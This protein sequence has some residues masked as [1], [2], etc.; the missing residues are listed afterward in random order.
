MMESLDS[1]KKA[2][3]S[4]F[5]SFNVQDS[6]SSGGKAS[7]TP[8]KQINWDKL[9]VLLKPNACNGDI[10]NKTQKSE[11]E[12]VAI[13]IDDSASENSNSGHN[14]GSC[15]VGQSG[16]H[17]GDRS[18]AHSL[19]DHD[20][21]IGSFN[22]TSG[23]ISKARKLTQG[24]IDGFFQKSPPPVRSSEKTS[25]HSQSVSGESS[26]LSQNGQIKSSEQR[27]ESEKSRS[28]KSHHW[29]SSKS[30]HHKKERSHSHSSSK[31]HDSEKSSKSS[32]EKHSSSHKSSHHRHTKSTGSHSVSSRNNEIKKTEG[33][34]L[35]TFNMFEVT[36]MSLAK[37]LKQGDSDKVSPAKKSHTAVSA[38]EKLSK[39]KLSKTEDVRKDKVTEKDIKHSS[40]HEKSRHKSHEKS[41]NSTKE[42]AKVIEGNHRTP[43]KGR[44]SFK[45]KS[46][47]DSP[48][49]KTPSKIGSHSKDR[50]HSEEKR[51]QNST[52][53]HAKV[54]EGN[55]KTPEK[56][57]HSFKPSKSSQGSPNE[58]TPSKIGSHSKD[59]GHSEEK[60]TPQKHHT[61]QKPPT[62]QN[63][64]SSVKKD[65]KGDHRQSSSCRVITPEMIYSQVYGSDVSAPKV[66]NTLKPSS[67]TSL[68]KVEHKAS[69]K[70]HRE[71]SKDKSASHDIIP[72]KVLE[73]RAHDY[74][75]SKKVQPDSDYWTPKNVQSDKGESSQIL[76]KHFYKSD[77][78]EGLNAREGNSSKSH[79]KKTDLVDIFNMLMDPSDSESVPSK[80]VLKNV[81]QVPNKSPQVKT[82]NLKV[83]NKN[84]FATMANFSTGEAGDKAGLDDYTPVSCSPNNSKDSQDISESAAACSTPV[85]YELKK[86]SDITSVDSISALWTDSGTTNL[87]VPDCQAKSQDSIEEET[88]VLPSIPILAEIG[89]DSWNTGGSKMH[90]DKTIAGELDLETNVCRSKSDSLEEE[91]PESKTG[92][93]NLSPNPEEEVCNFVS[94]SVLRVPVQE[95][96]DISASVSPAPGEKLGDMVAP[97][98][99][100]HV[101]DLGG[102]SGSVPVLNSCSSDLTVDDQSTR[103]QTASAG[104]E[105]ATVE[106]DIVSL[107]GSSVFDDTASSCVRVDETSEMNYET[108]LTMISDPSDRDDKSSV[109]GFSVRTTTSTDMSSS[110]I[111]K[112]ISNDAVPDMSAVAT[113]SKTVIPMQKVTET[114]LTDDKDSI[115][116]DSPVDH[117]EN[118]E[119]KSADGA[120]NVGKVILVDDDTVPFGDEVC[121]VGK[122]C[123][124]VTSFSSLKNL[125]IDHEE[126]SLHLH[127]SSE[128]SL[129]SVS[130][131]IHC[132][133]T[134]E[135]ISFP[136]RVGAS[137]EVYADAFVENE[138]ENLE[139]DQLNCSNESVI[140]NCVI[141]GNEVKG[142]VE[143]VDLVCVQG[144]EGP[145]L[146]VE[147]QDKTSMKSTVVVEEDSV[148]SSNISAGDF[149][150]AGVIEAEEYD[151]ESV[152]DLMSEIDNVLME[153]GETG[154]ESRDQTPNRL[155]VPLE[156]LW[157][158]QP[159]K[160][161]E[162]PCD[163]QR[164]GNVPSVSSAPSKKTD[165]TISLIEKTL[166][167]SCKSPLQIPIASEAEAVSELKPSILRQE[168][169]LN[170]SDVD[171]KDAAEISKTSMSLESS[172][173]EEEEE[174]TPRQ[175]RSRTRTS[176][177]QSEFS[178]PAP[179]IPKLRRSF[180]AGDKCGL[181]AAVETV[182]KES[183]KDK[184][185]TKLQMVPKEAVGMKR[186]A[187][188][189]V[190]P[191]DIDFES[192][193][194]PGIIEKD[195]CKI[196]SHL[197]GDLTNSASD[198]GEL[199]RKSSRKRKVKSMGDDVI[200]FAEAGTMKSDF[201]TQAHEYFPK[202]VPDV[203]ASV[204]KETGSAK[205][206]K[207][208]LPAS[209]TNSVETAKEKGKKTDKASE[210]DSSHEPV[211]RLRSPA[212]AEMH[213]TVKEL[214]RGLPSSPG[215]F[216]K[217]QRKSLG[218]IK[219]VAGKESLSSNKRR[220]VDTKVARRASD[221]DKKRGRTV[222]CD[223]RKI[224]LSSSISKSNAIP[225]RKR[226]RS[227]ELSKKRS[228][229]SNVKRGRGRPKKDVVGLKVQNVKKSVEDAKKLKQSDSSD[230]SDNSDEEI[231]DDDDE[232]AAGSE[233]DSEEITD[234]ELEKT[235][236]SDSFAGPGRRKKAGKYSYKK[237]DDYRPANVGSGARKRGRPRKCVFR[238]GNDSERDSSEEFQSS[239]CRPLKRKM[240]ILS[241]VSKIAKTSRKTDALTAAEAA[242]AK[243]KAEKEQMKNRHRN[244]VKRAISTQNHHK[245]KMKPFKRK[246]VRAILVGERK[247][248][249]RGAKNRVSMYYS[250]GM[251]DM[252]SD[253]SEGE[254]SS[255][256]DDYLKDIYSLFGGD[257][258]DRASAD[259][260][261]QELDSTVVQN[262]LNIPYYPEI[263][264]AALRGVQNNNCLLVFNDDTHWNDVAEEM[265]SR[266]ASICDKFTGAVVT[267]IQYQFRD[268]ECSGYDSNEP[269]VK[270]TRK[271][272][273]NDTTSPSS[274]PRLKK[275]YVH[276]ETK[277]FDR[278]PVKLTRRE[279]ARTIEEKQD[280][281]QTNSKHVPSIASDLESTPIK[282][283]N[284]SESRNDTPG[285]DSSVVIIN[286]DNSQ[287]PRKKDL[288][289]DRKG[290]LGLYEEF[291]SMLHKEK[292]RDED[293]SEVVCLDGTECDKQDRNDTSEQDEGS[294]LAHN[295]TIHK[296]VQ[297]TSREVGKET[298][299]TAPLPN[300]KP[301]SEPMDCDSLVGAND[302]NENI[303]KSSTGVKVMKRIVKFSAS[304]EL[305]KSFGPDKEQTSGDVISNSCKSVRV[306]KLDVPAEETEEINKNSADSARGTL[307]SVRHRDSNNPSA[308]E[309]G[310]TVSDKETN[311]AIS[312]EKAT[313][314]DDGD[315]KEA[316]VSESITVTHVSEPNKL[317]TAANDEDTYILV[318]CDGEFVLDEKTNIMDLTGESD[319]AFLE[320]NASVLSMEESSSTADDPL[321]RE[322][323]EA[324]N[325]DHNYVKKRAINQVWIREEDYKAGL[326]N[327]AV[328]LQDIG[329]LLSFSNEVGAF[330]DNETR[331]TFNVQ[332]RIPPKQDE[333][334][335][336]CQ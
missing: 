214:R 67:K 69:E 23:T 302:E 319:V 123:E 144:E 59:R 309:Q 9:S 236:D 314:F 234:S 296:S 291:M 299:S 110:I 168:A 245:L 221:S 272:K 301:G 328:N 51:T 334:N 332:E 77:R 121:P 153:I 140:V 304:R 333:P 16:Y 313:D 275:K 187:N 142:C 336:D 37:R 208:N 44:H 303:S 32:G 177:S 127:L 86:V 28:E 292:K 276:N 39:D 132:S 211:R 222:S 178:S 293:E 322:L 47:Q 97:V 235:S 136:V 88:S 99:A 189:P 107:G 73:N 6:D 24:K 170:E 315:K 90:Q 45:P 52:N 201:Y 53:E 11:K 27:T 204:T 312:V 146:V 43:E 114:G 320:S 104:N 66:S 125:G 21:T 203:E 112:D 34:D 98:P 74:W 19:G 93:P 152:D 330:V 155:E 156:G 176:D 271:S 218:F 264:E 260:S 68:P 192:E 180:K 249:E 270:R 117:E 150:M 202:R 287:S 207:S 284:G 60:R 262:P 326:F 186:P 210:K 213:S 278:T 317:V 173:S 171:K 247:R 206:A 197:Q 4:L 185:V 49:E 129:D 294:V 259:G 158:D 12:S 25:F 145:I 183:S 331:L 105:Q 130:G 8:L 141:E 327:A 57:R 297:L 157:S 101:G 65:H 7:P 212:K 289:K 161:F 233:S 228:S 92:S 17:T 298:G 321:V 119:V 244:L 237:D 94:P 131:E 238:P 198:T 283:N 230:M 169:A 95:H 85:A 252:A 91:K 111:F 181:L 199:V 10:S 29:E 265:P 256:S 184:K 87:R 58:K 241:P 324:I 126:S 329:P 78:N 254:S 209:K 159:P 200:V 167:D 223:D 172:S 253:Y 305:T 191:R 106:S 143:E 84:V 239:A 290:V 103:S 81:A 232:F 179:R 75:T 48:N 5:E 220:S 258:A 316:N 154:Q 22:H 15:I 62:S 182:A 42:H 108:Y 255:S 116:S 268:D 14:S 33:Q 280:H 323:V 295:A 122:A 38:G 76:G 151:A 64:H 72:K 83:S 20:N 193:S 311:D 139:Q 162:E 35:R 281:V 80:S 46:S 82:D 225:S 61:P 124:L 2:R 13:D 266:C 190:I 310:T 138:E 217:D 96:G 174:I 242:A 137:P 263:R 63:D 274:K 306:S 149:T 18:E 257:Q 273:R 166:H 3:P 195:S 115:G 70:G 246:Q 164:V 318:D 134:I 118:D 261:D 40:S 54:I 277:N 243:Q 120:F 135:D 148:L 227:D 133:A 216:S 36:T 308:C 269:E 248:L 113:Q 267:S 196:A 41:S 55:H 194:E 109:S 147:E 165:K 240:H 286:S 160:S 219:R 307:T 30:G 188:R 231:V 300:G 205:P 282:V 175:T 31:R 102:V 71:H 226:N 224:K 79:K 128:D 335:A 250:D 100:A 50:G 285:S 325:L 279:K 163:E 1:S 229:E 26:K 215:K 89:S 56:S 288:M 251:E